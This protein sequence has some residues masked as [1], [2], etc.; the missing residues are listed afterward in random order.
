MKHRV[1]ILS[2]FGECSW[3]TCL[4]LEPFSMYFI[5]LSL[6]IVIGFRRTEVALQR[7]CFLGGLHRDPLCRPQTPVWLQRSRA[8][9]SR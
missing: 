7:H 1:G 6:K 4:L 5:F 8:Q 3:K 9:S 2:L